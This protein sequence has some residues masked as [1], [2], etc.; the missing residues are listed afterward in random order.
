MKHNEWLDKLA[1]ECGV[2]VEEL[3]EVCIFEDANPP[4]ICT[5]CGDWVIAIEPDSSRGYCESCGN[6]TVKSALVLAGII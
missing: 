3:L 5:I 4:G 1:E 2:S 6:N